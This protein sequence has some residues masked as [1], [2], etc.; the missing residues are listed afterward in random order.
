MLN[1]TVGSIAKQFLNFVNMNQTPIS[2]GAVVIGIVS[3]V[4]L[5]VKAGKESEEDILE[6]Q[7]ELNEGEE[8]T[9]KD[10]VKTVWKRFIPVILVTVL[11]ISCLI[12]ST[13]HM[14][15]RYAALSTAYAISENYLKDYMEA[16]KDTVGEKK[17]QA[18]R[19][20]AM[21]KQ[22]ARHP[23]AERGIV[24][25]GKGDDL[26]YDSI[27]TRYFRTNMDSVRKAEKYLAGIY[28]T[29]GEV[30]LSEY[31]YSLGL[32]AS[33]EIGDYIGWKQR[34]NGFPDSYGFLYSSGLAPDTGEPYCAIY[35]LN[36]LTDLTH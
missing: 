24:E 3:A 13:K 5:A 15:K 27:T 28:Q 20:N 16:T 32:G 1:A 19:D 10:I 30:K 26:F 6:L 11:T 31:T 4:I 7:E 33:S 2:T 8:L 23:I 12:V 22:V 17:E 29:E 14:M 25:T 21:E 36:L 9:S 34:G 35:H 18:I